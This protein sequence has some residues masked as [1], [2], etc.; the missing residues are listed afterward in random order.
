ME[1]L[2]RR[3]LILNILLFGFAIMMITRMFNHK[4]IWSMIYFVRRGL[5]CE[6]NNE[7]KNPNKSARD[8][9]LNTRDLA[10]TL[11]G[12]PTV[13]RLMSNSPEPIFP[14]PTYP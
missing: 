4:K 1:A 8:M 7:K 3:R 12:M 14:W 10:K 13:R 11:I 5:S 6:M 9:W 2:N